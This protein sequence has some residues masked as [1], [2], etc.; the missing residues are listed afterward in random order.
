MKKDQIA[1]D[2]FVLI[3]TCSA[4]VDKDVD[5]KEDVYENV[6]PKPNRVEWNVNP[7]TQAYR[8]HDQL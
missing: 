5:D 3:L 8:E 6:P 1:N 4:E 2:G 7:K